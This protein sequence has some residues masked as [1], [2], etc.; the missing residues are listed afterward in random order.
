M[1][2]MK[3]AVFRLS[4]NGTNHV[5][6]SINHMMTDKAIGYS[7]FCLEVVPKYTLSHITIN[8]VI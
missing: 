6:T 1:K 3:A 4:L 2:A 5:G 8:S 7:M